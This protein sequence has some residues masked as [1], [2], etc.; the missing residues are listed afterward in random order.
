MPRRDKLKIA[1]VGLTFPFRGGI[2]HYTT[3]LCRSLLRKHEV[4]FY[5]LYRQ[6]PS[7][8]F[9]GKTQTDES[10]A[11]FEVPHRPC[12]DSINP[13]T[14]L[15]TAVRIVKYKPDVILVMNSIYSDEITQLTLELGITAELVS[16]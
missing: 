2:S 1:L 16:V 5:S 9:P 13:Y 12:V 15:A 8:L 10:D 11:P 14:W 7:L 4:R 3:L 6:Y